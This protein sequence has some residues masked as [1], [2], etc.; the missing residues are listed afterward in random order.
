MKTFK[1]KVYESPEDEILKSYIIK[2]RKIDIPASAFKKILFP[3]NFTEESQYNIYDRIKFE[4]TIIVSIKLFN[5]T[6]IKIYAIESCEL[7]NDTGEIECDDCY[8]T[9]DFECGECGSITDCKNCF[10]VGTIQCEK[11]K[12]DP[13]DKNNIIFSIDIQSNQTELF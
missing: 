1:D 6:V 13:F 10:G 5:K 12:D 7:C 3:E 9:G 8:G 11:C 2:G 4:P